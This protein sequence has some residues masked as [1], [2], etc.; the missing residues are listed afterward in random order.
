[1]CRCSLGSLACSPSLG[2][3]TWQGDFIDLPTFQSPVDAIF[4]NAVFGN[5]YSQH[6]ALLKAALLL[7][8]GGTLVVRWVLIMARV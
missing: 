4:M 5:V 1:L 8:P 6:E 2:V 7:R 3:R